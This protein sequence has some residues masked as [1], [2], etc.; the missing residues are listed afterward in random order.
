MAHSELGWIYPTTPTSWVPVNRIVWVCHSSFQFYLWSLGKPRKWHYLPLIVILTLYRD[1]K[2]T[3]WWVDENVVVSTEYP[4]TE[5]PKLLNSRGQHDNMTLAVL[6]SKL[7][8]KIYWGFWNSQTSILVY[9]LPTFIII[10][11]ALHGGYV[12]AGDCPSVCWLV[13]LFVREQNLKTYGFPS[14]FHTLSTC[15]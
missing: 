14:N 11:S 2:M 13:C 10:T 12:F 5:S 8:V 3:N 4:V 9:I 1:K 15:A 7:N 6:H